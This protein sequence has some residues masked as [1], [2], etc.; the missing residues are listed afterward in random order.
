[1]RN[2]FTLLL[3]LFIFASPDARCGNIVYPWR[4]TTAIV[5]SGETFEVWFNADADQTVDSVVLRGP[6]NKV[7]ATITA[8]D[9]QTWVYDQWSG[10]TC[11]LRLTVSVPTDTPS[12]RY[13]LILKTSGGDVISLAAVKVIKEYK[14]LYY[15]MH[16]SDAHRWQGTYDTP[17]IILREISTIIGIANIIDPEMLIE[18]GDN[19]Y[20][21]TNNMASTRQRIIEYMNGFMNGNDFILGM[22]HS[23]APVFSV[24][25]NHD[26]PQ[27]NYQLEPDMKTPSLYFNEHYGLQAHNFT[28]GNARFIGVN[29]AWFPDDGTGVP[30]FAHQTDETKIWLAKVGLGNI[31]IGYCH[32]NTPQP[33]KAFN[34][35]LKSMNASLNLI[36]VGHC[37]SI[38][39]SPFTVDNKKMAYS[40]LS[41]R[42]GTRKA[43]FNLYQIDAIAGT[44]VTV[45]NEQAFQEGLEVAKDYNTSK[46]K[47]LY[48]KANNG[49][50]YDNVA[51]IINKFNF[52]INGARARFV[53]PKDSIYYITNG[54]IRQEFEG[55]DFYVVDV[56]IDLEAKS[57]TEIKLGAGIRP[58]LCPDDPFKMDPGICGCG[59]EE[60]TCE[61]NVTGVNVVPSK[62]KI[63]E[64]VSRQFN[65]VIVPKNATNCT[66][67]WSS[68]NTDVA[69]V[70]PDGMVT[71]IAQGTT[72]ITAITED[73]NIKAVSDVTVI[74]NN[75]TYQAEYAEFSGPVIETNQSGYRGEGFL[76][77]INSSNDYIKWSVH[78]PTTNTYT[79]SFRYALASGNRPLK[80]TINDEVK[81]ASVSFPVTSTWTNWTNYTT[82]QTLTAGTNTIML[83]ATG[84]S[85]GNF[86][87]LSIIGEDL[88]VNTLNHELNEKSVNV[89]PN[90]AN[91]GTFSINL[92]GFEKM[93]N[94]QVTISNL[95][96]QTIYQK[97]LSNPTHVEISGLAL[98]KTIYII[99]VESEQT[100]IVKKLV[101]N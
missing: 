86:D 21:N 56:S 48:A 19:H 51:T 91:K 57:T 81:I 72:T 95:N 89:Y 92:N 90:P 74:F 5:K 101:V 34:D 41:P 65:A 94:V 38:T 44:Y 62:A 88:N 84:A 76:D 7:N 14:N 39:N 24:P 55:T 42:E 31:R 15:V 66:V 54:T 53:L 23:F 26:T 9:T 18:T 29:N 35:P 68:S 10:N 28:Y 85:G 83:T 13:D 16:M 12:D 99:S 6:F 58:D 98:E 87:E 93:N 11:N 46:L 30:N 71:A 17:N 75:H 8:T 67:N 78:V 61:I 22:N 59:V 49:T 47:L 97:N 4:A 43:P 69:I 33:L 25:G 40:T 96:G 52:P 82:I 37:H 100:K 70:S 77:F 32:V 45:G 73:G 50:N 80:L 60:G 64:M 1:M 3:V 36:M 2:K 20:P 63:N 79:L 27:K